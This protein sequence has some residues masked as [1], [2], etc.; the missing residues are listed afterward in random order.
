MTLTLAQFLDLFKNPGGRLY[1]H[2]TPEP[3]RNLGSQEIKPPGRSWA[4]AHKQHARPTPLAGGIALLLGVPGGFNH[5]QFVA[6]PVRN[7]ND[8]RGHNIHLWSLG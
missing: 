7:V 3:T 8:L 2:R 5:L 6:V 1:C 4:A